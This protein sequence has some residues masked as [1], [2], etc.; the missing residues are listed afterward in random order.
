MKKEHQNPNQV[1]F[2]QVQV[3]AM[4]EFHVAYIRHIG[5]Y[6]GDNAL[7]DNLFGRLMTWAGPRGLLRFPETKILAV[8]HDD[9]NITDA[10]KLRTS[11]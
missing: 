8:Y 9:P 2:E 7:F 11:V 4:P 3:K 6:Q 10:N 1:H 5:P